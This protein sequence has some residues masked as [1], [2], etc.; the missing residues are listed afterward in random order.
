MVGPECSIRFIVF[1][2]SCIHS[3]HAIGFTI[4]KTLTVKSCTLGGV[5]TCGASRDSPAPSPRSDRAVAPGLSLQSIMMCCHFHVLAGVTPRSPSPG[6]A[7]PRLEI[8]L[9]RQPVLILSTFI[10]T[11][12]SLDRRSS[13]A[14]CTTLVPSPSRFV[15]R[16]S[17]S[18]YLASAS[19]TLSTCC[20]IS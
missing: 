10:A 9:A 4:T 12:A 16:C 7:R 1:I 2:E 19:E 17:I 18:P 14:S 20:P 6:L 8:S 5:L 15:T 11:M 13:R 3:L